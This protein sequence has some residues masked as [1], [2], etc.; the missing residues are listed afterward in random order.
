MALRVLPGIEQTGGTGAVNFNGG[1]IKAK[2]SSLNFMSGLAD[3]RIYSGNA[4]FDTD[5]KDITIAQNLLGAAG[6]GVL[7]IPVT[8]GGAGYLAPPIVQITG[9]G[10]Q[11]HRSGP[12]GSRGWQGPPASS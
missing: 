7:S 6:N 1:T 9:D 3:A 11:R 10:S 5:G 12:D 2:A 4:I 8:D